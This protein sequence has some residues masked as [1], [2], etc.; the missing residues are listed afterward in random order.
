MESAAFTVPG[1]FGATKVGTSTFTSALKCEA[2][3]RGSEGGVRMAVDAFQKKFQTF[4][5]IGIDYSRPKKLAAYKRGGFDAASIEYPNQPSFA[6]KYQI[7]NC[8]RMSGTSKILMK[9]DEYCAKGM[10]QVFKRSAVPYGVYTTACTEGTTKGM[11][12]DKR[13]FNRTLA[14]KQA[15]K[16]VKMRLTEMYEA[17]RCAFIMAN[18]CHREEQQFKNMPMSAATYLAAKSEASGA[19]YRTVTPGS[20]AE[21]YMSS[22]IRMQLKAK[23]NPYGVYTVGVCAEGFAKGDAEMLRVAALSAEYR[24]MQQSPAKVTGSAYEASRTAIKLYAQN[25]H[26]EQEQLCKWPATAAAFCR[27]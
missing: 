4:G 18:G 7:S 1:M 16:P 20:V 21:D 6:G 23:G 27:Y 17:R 5:K 14:F 25:C 10:L 8:G 11:A 26:H 15:Q 12:H 19:C 13:V 22:G 3:A 9:Y 2:K 24:A